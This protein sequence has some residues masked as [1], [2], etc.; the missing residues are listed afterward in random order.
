[1]ERYVG[2]I[3]GIV[4]GIVLLL[5]LSARAFAGCQTTCTIN[6]WTGQMVCNEWCW[7]GDKR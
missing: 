4:I 3:A 7:G 6:P 2:L 5:A 1:M